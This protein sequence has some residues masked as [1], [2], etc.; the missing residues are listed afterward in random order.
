M[1]HKASLSHLETDSLITSDHFYTFERVFLLIKFSRFHSKNKTATRTSTDNLIFKLFHINSRLKVAIFS[2]GSD[3]AKMQNTCA[4][5][6]APS[7]LAGGTRATPRARPASLPYYWWTKSTCWKSNPMGEMKQSCSNG[8]FE[9][10]DF[11]TFSERVILRVIFY[12]P[13]ILTM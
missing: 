8:T 5:G 10:T 7:T 6:R 11:K 2:F 3:G 12:S 9:T 1:K 13:C 4:R